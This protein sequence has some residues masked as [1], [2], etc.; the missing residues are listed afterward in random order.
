MSQTTT[1]QGILLI[2]FDAAE[3]SRL[4]LS[5]G[6]AGHRA[7][8]ARGARDAGDLVKTGQIHLA[9][10]DLAGPFAEVLAG[11]DTVREAGRARIPV[12]G[13]GEVAQCATITGALRGLGLTGLVPVGASP[14]EVV[15]RVNQVLFADRQAANRVSPR[16]PVNL[17]ASFDAPDGPSQG[18][19][20]NVSETGL[21]LSTDM[22]LP[23]NRNVTVRFALRSGAEPISVTCRVVWT[24]AGGEGLRYFKGMGL[25]FLPMR[26][27]TRDELKVFLQ[28]SLATLERTGATPRSRPL[29]AGAAQ[30]AATAATVRGGAAARPSVN[31]HGAHRAGGAV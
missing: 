26:P 31:G 5:L 8:A 9:L 28:E 16:V 3:T 22:L 29:E 30:P 25:Q 4:A 18:R 20:L 15:F 17:P 7:H 11:L 1:P 6:E 21:F 19:I 12:L 14:Q 2:G 24:N 13:M 27:A 10:A 23:V